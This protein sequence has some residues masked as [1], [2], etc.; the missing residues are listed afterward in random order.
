MHGYVGE[1]G[2]NRVDQKPL[3]RKQ[4]SR[5][6][7]TERGMAYRMSRSEQEPNTKLDY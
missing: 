6:T 2:E 7:G 1:P 5:L 3:R 4:R